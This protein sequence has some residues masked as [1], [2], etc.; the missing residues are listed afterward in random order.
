[1]SGFRAVK[2]KEPAGRDPRPGVARSGSPAQGRPL[3]VAR[4]GVEPTPTTPTPEGTRDPGQKRH[5]MSA[6]TP[7]ERFCAVAPKARALGSADRKIGGGDRVRPG[8]RNRPHDTR[9]ET[10]TL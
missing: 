6:K 5:P 7:Y 4:S 1:M 9:G 8:A 10:D 3:R 2:P